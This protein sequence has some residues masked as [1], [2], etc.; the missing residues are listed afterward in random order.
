MR[1]NS[2]PPRREAEESEEL[3]DQG[4]GLMI[5]GFA[6]AVGAHD[7]QEESDRITAEDRAASGEAAEAPG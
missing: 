1:P 4:L 7:L 3:A 6:E 5:M 2:L